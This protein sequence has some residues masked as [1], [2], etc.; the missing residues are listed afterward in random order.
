[1]KRFESL[2]RLKCETARQPSA[3][4]LAFTLAPA[5]EGEVLHIKK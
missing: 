1:L 4:I 3:F 5:A 2:E